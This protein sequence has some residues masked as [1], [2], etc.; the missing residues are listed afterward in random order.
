MADWEE[1][2]RIVELV[3]RANFGVCLDTYHILARLWVDPTD[4]KMGVRPGGKVLWKQ[5]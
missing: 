3:N 5:A 4:P 2:S 1:F